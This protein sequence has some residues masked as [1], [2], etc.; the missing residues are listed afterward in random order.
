M[1]EARLLSPVQAAQYLGL[2]SRWAVYRLVSEGQ[3][4]AIKLA[5][6]LRIDRGDLDRLVEQLKSTSARPAAS[7]RPIVTGAPP[8]LGPLLPIATHVHVSR[9]RASDSAGD[10]RSGWPLRPC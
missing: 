7:R 3:I 6:K 5:G 2:G 10:S 8:R 9:R 4:P 1:I